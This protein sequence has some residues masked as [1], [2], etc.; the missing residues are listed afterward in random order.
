[1]QG[2]GLTPGA[3]ER[4]FPLLLEIAEGYLDQGKAELA[5]V[6]ARRS[7]AVSSPHRCPLISAL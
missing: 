2:L 6:V 1:M 5:E 3:K 4:E 7:L